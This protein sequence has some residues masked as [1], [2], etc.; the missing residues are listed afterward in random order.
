MESRLEGSSSE[1]MCRF[2]RG[3]NDGLKVHVNSTR[4]HLKNLISTSPPLDWSQIRVCRLCTFFMRIPIC[5]GRPS[6]LDCS[7]RQM[8]LLEK[9]AEYESQQEHAWLRCAQAHGK[10][11][12]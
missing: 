2:V 11:N 8:Q 7:S 5:F 1:L 12:G 9:K 4:R 10:T 3:F 6:L